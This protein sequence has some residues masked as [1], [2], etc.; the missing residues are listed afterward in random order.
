MD[1]SHVVETASVIVAVASITGVGILWNTIQVYKENNTALEDR[2]K[3]IEEETARCEANHKANEKKITILEAKID[4]YKE[5]TL[6]PQDLIS[7]L[8]E[9]DNEILSLLKK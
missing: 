6:V 4:A 2:L 5:L 8:L 7:Q 3:I 9:K 1:L